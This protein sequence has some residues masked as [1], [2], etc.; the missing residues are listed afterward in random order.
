MI[1]LF[2]DETPFGSILVHVFHM[3]SIFETLAAS[4]E[5]EIALCVFLPL[6]IT[7]YLAVLKPT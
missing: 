1:Y 7:F 4:R 3:L 6:F 5:R 2:V